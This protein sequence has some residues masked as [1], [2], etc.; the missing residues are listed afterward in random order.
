MSNNTTTA[1][2]KQNK[3]KK[4]KNR[5]LWLGLYFPKKMTFNI[6]FLSKK[7]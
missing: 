2:V 5:L 4:E 3:E 1:Y 7:Q 6:I